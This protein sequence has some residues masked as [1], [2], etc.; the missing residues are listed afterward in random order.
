MSCRLNFAV[1]SDSQLKLK[2][3][4]N[5]QPVVNL[6]LP[7]ENLY[8]FEA[9]APETNNNIILR[10]PLKYLSSELN[11]VPLDQ[12]VTIRTLFNVTQSN[13]IGKLM[14]EINLTSLYHAFNSLTNLDLLASFNSQ[15]I[16]ISPEVLEVKDARDKVLNW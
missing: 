5:K 16:D 13:L 4:N 1:C 8:K 2:K 9:A 11:N 14:N 3:F 7:L 6:S 12:R 15:D 10:L